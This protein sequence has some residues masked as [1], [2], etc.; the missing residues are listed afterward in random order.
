MD[1]PE[2]KPC[3]RCNDTGE[4]DSGGMYPWGEWITIPCD[5][6]DGNEDDQQDQD[7]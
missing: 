3:P 2:R 7:Q 5:C 4:T 6:L 1:K